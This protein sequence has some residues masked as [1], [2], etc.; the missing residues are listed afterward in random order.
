MTY[1]RES[2]AVRIRHLLIVRNGWYGRVFHSQAFH[3]LV[4]LLNGGVR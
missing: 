3:R 2:R 1:I 4:D